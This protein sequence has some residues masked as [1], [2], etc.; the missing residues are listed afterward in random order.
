MGQDDEPRDD[1]SPSDIRILRTV[2]LID[3]RLDAP[4]CAIEVTDGGAEL[5]AGPDAS[6]V[7][8][9]PPQHLGEEVWQ[10]TPLPPAA[11]SKPTSASRHVAADPSRLVYEVPEG[12]RIDYTLEGVLAALADLRLR[13]SPLAT[14]PGE[15]TAEE[16]DP[17]PPSDLETS[18]EAPFRMV[19]S[20]SARGAFRH[21]PAPVGPAGRAELWRT[22]L[23]VRTDT[24]LDDDDADQRVVRALWTRD[25]E[26]PDTAFLQPLFP[27]DRRAIVEQTHGGK[28]ANADTPL[29]V[30]RLSLSSLG[31]WFD[32]RQ[33]WPF[34]S[35]VVD[36]RHQAFMGRDAYVRVA[37]SGILFP[38]GHRCFLVHVTEREVKHRDQPVAYLWQRWFIIVRQPTRGYPTSDRD[39]PFGQIIV[40]PLVTPDIDAPLESVNQGPFIPTRDGV[41][42]PFTLTTLDRGGETRS[43]AAPLVFVQARNQ[44][45]RTSFLNPSAAR[46]LYATVARVQ[47]RG[48]TLAVAKPVKAGDTSV[49]VTHLVL[50]GEIDE[51]NLTSRPF[52]AETRAVV[53]SMRHLAPQAPAVDLV[54]AK[55]YL[56][57]GLPDRAPDAPPV[58]GAPNTGEL[59]LALKSPAAAV[60]FTKG[61]DR[62]G[63]FVAPNLSVRG[64]SRALGAT[65]VSGD[66][67]SPFDAGTFDPATFLAGAL[68]KLFGLFSLTELLGAAGLDEAPGFVSDALEPLAKL[69]AEAQRLRQALADAQDR[70]DA[71]IADGAHGGAKALA[72]QAKDALDARVGG[73]TGA[74]DALV[75]AVQVV[76]PDPTTV[77]TAAVAL[78]G[79]LELLL[80]DIGLPGLPAAVRSALTK[81]VQVLQSFIAIVRDGE[82]LAK[83]L[84]GLA[85]GQVTARLE[86]HPTIG[87]WGLAGP[88]AV[89][90]IFVPNGERKLRI[91][92]EV[93]ASA[94]A[95]PAVDIL[96]ELVDFDLNLIGDREAALMKLTF[97]R[98]AF[99][100]GSSGKPEVD[101]VFGGIGFLGPLG[102]VDR[103]REL[104]PFDGF[105]DP[106]FVDITPEGVTAGFDITLPNVSVGVFSLE[107]IALGADARVPFLGDAMT[108]GFHFCSKDAPFRLT[109]MCIGGGG[110]LGLR[111]SPKGLVLLEL[112]LEACASLSIDLGVASG[113]VSIAVGV[114]LRLEADKGLLTAY[115]RIRGEV[116]VLGLISAS[117]TL[118]LSLTYHFETGKLI[119]RASLVVEIEI[120]FFS[121]SVE[122]SVERKLAGSKGDPTMYQVMPPDAAG[123]NADWAEYCGAFAPLPA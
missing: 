109:V 11:P 25:D 77:T 3:L 40:S 54:F 85:G 93:R 43:W 6:L 103:L 5:V 45:G 58:P 75:G 55:P 114:Y 88:P 62:S 118:E 95:P 33:S 27:Y 34:G 68:P 86:W 101:V 4:G 12:T 2:D 22:H 67:P 94:S 113:S 76:P 66:T 74:L 31:A 100:A 57:D 69:V 79:E 104:I 120:L 83:L 36:Y 84:Q 123:M 29:L 15:A 18:I 122:I 20:P 14:P 98:V 9:F 89:P 53:P 81:P 71:E 116:D 117:I 65:G 47:G 7:V 91:D 107:N 112:G 72:Q 32:W 13:V 24:G 110:W 19:V 17:E 38:I 64:I 119:G 87:A 42:F 49:E 26:Q 8:H 51:S 115:F 50:D 61:S 92:V 111:A 56:A 48:Q 106:P 44:E 23:S 99:H 28:P 59:I 105:S 52:L 97:R 30:N 80:R 63:G 70:L 60:D 41:P 78:T 10:T 82:E 73:L 46:G 39:N 102:F 121:A 108:V 16:R 96:A 37:Y 90:N 21:T 1:P 35:T